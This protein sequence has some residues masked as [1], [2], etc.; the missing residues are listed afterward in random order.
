VGDPFRRVSAGQRL[1]PSANAWNDILK[2]T[3]DRKRQGERPHPLLGGQPLV[4]RTDVNVYNPTDGSVPGIS[5]SAQTYDRF[6]VVALRDPLYPPATDDE[7][8]IAE[9]DQH[10]LL[11]AVP[12]VSPGTS[13]FSSRYAICLEPIEPGRIGRACF[14]GGTLAKVTAG[15]TADYCTV[16][17]SAGS[18]TFGK[19]VGGAGSV[20]IMWLDPGVDPSQERLALVCLDGARRTFAFA[21]FNTG[22]YADTPPMTHTAVLTDAPAGVALGTFDVTITRQM[23][24]ANGPYYL[25]VLGDDGRYSVVDPGEVIIGGNYSGGSIDVGG[26][27]V[28]VVGSGLGTLIDNAFAMAAYGPNSGSLNYTAFAQGCAD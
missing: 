22:F 1:A 27:S 19:L 21:L 23:Y 17:V 6:A 3:A 2:Q 12:P 15:N 13:H 5:L 7:A 26:V 25:A 8:K 4:E 24:Y 16:D 14:R 11:V 28:P 20:R 10:K 9:F 18:P